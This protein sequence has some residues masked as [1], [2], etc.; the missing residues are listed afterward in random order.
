[1]PP[2]SASSI[3]RFDAIRLPFQFSN[4][5]QITQKWFVVIAHENGN[6]ICVKATSKVERYKNNPYLMAG[7]AFF[8]VG[9]IPC[10][11]KETALQ[12]DNRFEIPHSLIE[13]EHANGKVTIAA[14]SVDCR[15]RLI[16]SVTKSNQLNRRERQTILEWLQ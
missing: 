4:S 2:F 8:P 9:E 3:A 5:S 13:R 14:T 10:F 1:M 15:E 6:A 7:C 11:P 12:P 16:A